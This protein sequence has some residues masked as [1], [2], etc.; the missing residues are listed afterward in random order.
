MK[1]MT[2]ACVFQN[3]PTDTISPLDTD[4]TRFPAILL[5]TAAFSILLRPAEG[6]TSLKSLESDLWLSL[7]IQR[8]SLSQQLTSAK[9]I[10]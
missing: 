5:S 1:W 9:L 7:N 2:Q 6:S 3:E 8:P 4:L 10:R